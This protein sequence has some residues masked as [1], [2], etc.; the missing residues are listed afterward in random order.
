MFTEN[1]LPDLKSEKLDWEM[2]QADMKNKLGM[3]YL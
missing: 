2:V 1:K 3:D